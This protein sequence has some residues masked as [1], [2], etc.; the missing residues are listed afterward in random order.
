MY[1]Q[2]PEGSSVSYEEPR[3]GSSISQTFDGLV[4]HRRLGLFGPRLLSSY[5]RSEYA[6]ERRPWAEWYRLGTRPRREWKFQRHHYRRRAVVA[7]ESGGN[8]S[9]ADSSPLQAGRH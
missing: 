3:P 8:G 2:L 5:P 7:S 9:R 6:R 1:V 4:G